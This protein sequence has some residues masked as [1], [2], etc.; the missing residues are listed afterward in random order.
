MPAKRRSKS[1]KTK[2]SKPK[3]I[4]G[5]LYLSAV[6]IAI[7][8]GL[9]LIFTA[10]SSPVKTHADI[11][12]TDFEDFNLGTV[13]GQHGWT[14]NGQIDE[15][16]VAPQ[17]SFANF[18]IKS[19]RISNAIRTQN[20]NVVSNPLQ[21]E[22]GETEAENA[23]L[24]AGTRQP[25][26]ETEW[27]FASA[28]PD[29]VQQNLAIEANIDRGD[30]NPMS[31]I[32]MKDVLA[33]NVLIGNSYVNVPDGLIVLLEEYKTDLV[34][35]GN[36]GTYTSCSDARVV[37][38]ATGLSRN[39]S[40]HVKATIDFINGPNNDVVTVCVDDLSCYTGNSLE[41]MY[42]LGLSAPQPP[43]TVDSVLFRSSGGTVGGILGKGFYF[44]NFSIISSNPSAPTPIPTLTPDPQNNDPKDDCEHD[45][46]RDFE[47]PSFKN[48]GDCVSY[49]RHIKNGETSFRSFKLSNP[50]K[51][52]RNQ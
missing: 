23:S 4:I 45:G 11:Y 21:D 22:A 29:G 31:T 47:G 36:G 52:F 17:L 16:E 2:K 49:M 28:N 20:S 46:W 48:Q 26:F 44:D 39:I 10:F 14:V 9:V 27:D 34:C 19:F 30:A 3:I 8:G 42:R 7:L 18:G 35:V 32:T 1:A 24:S 13:A 41:D 38:I 33:G 12:S 37:P 6:V 25:H 50:S 5:K 40:H 15:E 43:K 51:R